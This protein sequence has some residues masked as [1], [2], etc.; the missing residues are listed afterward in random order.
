MNPIGLHAEFNNNTTQR[1]L[2]LIAGIFITDLYNTVIKKIVTN[3]VREQFH[4]IAS[5]T[6][7]LADKLNIE[8]LALRATQETLQILNKETIVL[9]QEA[10]K[11]KILA[12]V[13]CH[14]ITT[15]HEKK[16]LLKHLYHSNREGKPDLTLLN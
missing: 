15:I 3:D 12:V 8:G 10:S 13:T 6:T 16:H 2:G 11:N 7:E 14:V 9:H 5:K 4:I 1:Q